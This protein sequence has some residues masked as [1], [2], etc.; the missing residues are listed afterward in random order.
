MTSGSLQMNALPASAPE[1]TGGVVGAAPLA[2]PSA[3]L[4]LGA[5]HLLRIL[6]KVLQWLYPLCHYRDLD[7]GSDQFVGAGSMSSCLP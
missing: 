1:Y 4:P 6:M 5:A 7:S 3:P 2:A